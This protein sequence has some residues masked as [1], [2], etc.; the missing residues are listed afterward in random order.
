MGRDRVASKPD[1]TEALR[2][3]ARETDDRVAECLEAMADGR[4]VAGKS[5]RELMAKYGVAWETV[6]NWAVAAGRMLRILARF[7]REDL[8]AR[9]ASQLERIVAMAL[10]KQVVIPV[11][12][13]DP[14]V[15]DQPDLKA[16][17]SAIAEQGK[18]LGLNA[19]EKVQHTFAADFEAMAPLE[20]AA[21]LEA[22]ASEWLT[23]A[24][25]IRQ[26]HGVVEG[27]AAP[28]ID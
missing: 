20:Q 4:W 3:R 12:N 5:H 17:V 15:V 8:R 19:P 6:R 9:N 7:D 2:V 10:E 16:A 25:R 18:L 24:A 11:K 21:W 26:E 13:G 28:S 14:I 22:K 23:E 1:L 27:E